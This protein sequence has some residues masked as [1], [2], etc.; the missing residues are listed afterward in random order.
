MSHTS[1]RNSLFNPL[2][3][4]ALSGGLSAAPIINEFMAA[5]ESG[6]LDEDGE[7]SDW[8]EIHNPDA[9]AVNLDGFALTDDAG[10]L[11]AWEFPDTTLAPGGYLI[12]FASNKNRAD[13]S[14][15]L[16]TNFRLSASGGYLALSGPS[17]VV[18]EFGPVYPEQYEDVSYGKVSSGGTVRDGFLDSPTPGSSNSAGDPAGPIFLETTDKPDRPFA[19][20]DFLVTAK[21]SA[22]SSA[23]ASVSMHYR[24]MFSGENTV[25]MV[26]NGAG[27]DAVGGDGIYSAL[28]PGSAFDDGEMIRWR[29]EATDA[30][31]FESKS[32]LFRDPFDSHQYVGTVAVDP[33][34]NSL[35]PV[36]EK[37]IQNPSAAETD[38]GTRGALFYLGELYD[39][40]FFN[41]HGQS[42]GGALFLKKSFNIDFN[43]TQRFLWRVGEKRVKDMDLLTNWADKSK[44]RHVLAWEIMREAGVNAHEAFTVR[45]QRNGDFFGT[46]D[47]VEDPDD[48]YLE[49]AGLNP[50]GALYKIYDIR[51]EPVDVAKLTNDDNLDASGNTVT[52]RAAEKK[53]RRDEDRSDFRDFING[54]HANSRNS[55]AQWDFIYDNV[56][57]PKM[58][59][60]AATFAVIRATDLHRKN[61][62]FYR[63][64]GR[65]DE[66]TM[67]PWDLDLSQGRKWNSTDKY[68]DST[69]FSTG[70]IEHGTAVDLLDIMWDRAEVRNMIHR[71]IRTLAD[72]FLQTEDTA[73]ELR[74]YERRLDEMLATID[75][76]SISP[77]DAQLDFEKWGSWI[78]VGDGASDTSGVTTLVPYTNTHAHV[79]S[80]LEAVDR[81]KTEYLPGRRSFI[82]SNGLIPD[83]QEGEGT[84]VQTTLVEADAAVKAKVPVDGG[85]DNLW[86]LPSFNDSSWAAGTMGVGFDNTSKYPPFIG[87]DTGAEMS[88]AIERAGVYLRIDFEV[89][90]P[91]IYQQLQLRMKYDDGYVAYL[92]G[93]K[94][95]EQLAPASPAWN[96]LATGSHEAVVTE[97]EVFD[98]SHKLDELVTGTNV[99]AIHGMNRT[100][101][102]S[103]FLIVAEL[104][105][106]VS[107]ASGSLEPVIEFG[108]IEFSPASGN[109]DEEY[110]ELVNNNSIWV[111]VSDWRIE[112]G[113]RMD[114]PPGTVIPPNSTLYVTP[115]AK[116]FRSRATSPTGDEGNLVVGSYD[117]HLSS[118]GETLQL[119]DAAGAQNSTETYV[120]DP[121]DAQQFLVISEVM[122]HPEPDGLAEYIE[123]LNI[124]D[125]VTLNLSGITFTEGISFDFTG[126]SVTSLAPGERVLVVKNV[127]A[128]EAAHSSGLPVAGVFADDSSLSNGGESIKLEDAIGGTIQEFSYNDS[129]PWPT[130]PDTAGHS[131]VLIAPENSP[132][133]ADAGNWRA[134]F[135]VGGT[136]GE[137]EAGNVFVGNP[138]AD[139][140]GDGFSALLEFAAGTSDNDATGVIA[141]SDLATV[142]G[143]DFPSFSYRADPTA[144]GLVRTIETS[145]NL[146]SWGDASAD[147]TETS[148]VTQADGTEIIRFQYSAPVTADPKRF[149]RL[150][151]ELN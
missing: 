146:L 101:G 150:K 12:V 97:Y 32:P 123:L 5:N 128:F 22:V 83:A 65:T 106:G 117:G 71:R 112:G 70:V 49:R 43:K 46:L 120:G 41:K 24:V 103:D 82:E 72:R 54:L 15:Q 34:V 148:R 127:A 91:S 33:A 21:M 107:D 134:S 31:G 110:V 29:F 23:V 138:D 37:F 81:W 102:S 76:P 8:I 60:L 1:M 151:V 92:N 26:D 79:E 51:L 100:L 3:L 39:N 124:S 111:D 6:L 56:S 118:L 19:G 11:T 57:L 50:D 130:T 98:I 18:S 40:V 122:Y 142:G 131:L 125:T 28:I 85:D 136:P 68:F 144:M 30:S 55:Q 38:N 61:W 116:A 47:F 89:G 113:I 17:G 2:C 109:Q 78:D 13:P 75:P 114:L 141:F 35:L 52:G 20:T 69:I 129:S 121:S 105:G 63:D 87:Y 108:A 66:W 16:H 104:S 132:V 95:H 4:F 119:L 25:A 140:D 133:H 145:T 137:A 27:P 53:N 64:T 62:Y 90:D 59:N 93:E 84:F 48:I 80:M 67:L 44:A 58:V 74:Y 94:I 45:V 73:Y 9:T 139:V 77:S 143:V 7:R 88:G 99:L 96:S 42:T 149:Y 10:E 147:F 14:G 135:A 115:D 86:M 126:A 36:V